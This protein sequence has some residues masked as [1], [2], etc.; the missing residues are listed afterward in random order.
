MLRHEARRAGQIR[1]RGFWVRRV[2][3]LVPPLLLVAVV[4]TLAVW[5]RAPPAGWAEQRSSLLWTLAYLANW[6]LLE[7][8]AWSG[9]TVFLPPLAHT[10]SLAVEEQFYLAWPLVMVAALALGRRRPRLATLLP[11]AVGV[12]GVVVSVWWLA[13]RYDPPNP[14]Q[15]Q[16]ATWGRSGELLAGA[17]LALGWTGAVRRLSPRQSRY[18]GGAGWTVLLVAVATLR[19][20]SPAYYHGGAVLVCAGVVAVLVGLDA[21]GDGAVR[22]LLSTRPFVAVGE[23]SYGLYLSHHV[24]MLALPIDGLEGPHLLAV[25]LCRLAVS[26]GL[27][28]LSYLA[29]ERPLQ[30]GTM[31]WVGRSTRRLLVAVAVATALTVAFSTLLLQP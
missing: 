14:V 1:L 27:A 24:V 23:I 17:L 31:P 10:W 7:V 19:F 29:L 4:A 18:V 16:F 22:R 15:A 12:G 28:V 5:F 25:Q 9:R 26:L 3:R 20:G 6:H 11:A 2:R 8:G 13:T 21:G 30:R